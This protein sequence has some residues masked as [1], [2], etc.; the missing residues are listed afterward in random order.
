MK[1]DRCKRVIRRLLPDMGCVEVTA[2]GKPLNYISKS[3]GR[4]MWLSNGL[5]KAMRE[6]LVELGD[7]APMVTKEK[8]IQE[9]RKVS[10]TN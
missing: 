2:R 8:D 9:S 10:W 3:T 5:R 7:A 1:G 6:L 4:R